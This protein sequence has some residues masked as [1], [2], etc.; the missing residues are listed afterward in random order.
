MLACGVCGMQYR[1]EGVG[2]MTWF[3]WSHVGRLTSRETVH[4]SAITPRFFQKVSRLA[5]PSRAFT[6]FSRLL[7]PD[8]FLKTRERKKEDGAMVLSGDNRLGVWCLAAE[9]GVVRYDTTNV[10]AQGVRFGWL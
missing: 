10:K 7:C 3:R 9:E 2:V 6:F 8:L 1:R 4:I 5:L